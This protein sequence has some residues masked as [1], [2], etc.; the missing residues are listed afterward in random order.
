MALCV[1]SA[2]IDPIDDIEL[3]D[4]LMLVYRDGGFT[5]SE[6]A[7]TIFEPAAVRARGEIL[8]EDGANEGLLGMVIVVPPTSSAAQFAQAGECEMQLLA[9]A[10]RVQRAG[11]GRAL[12]KAAME[13]A[14]SDGFIRMLLWTQ[15]AM[16][17]AQRLYESSG[18]TRIPERDFKRLGRDF[19][20]FEAT[21]I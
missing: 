13:R 15:L 18:F 14:Q 2:R 10:P 9:T 11:I 21:L 19:L 1:R 12:L 20:F 16:H 4:L 8:Y 17:A 7:E 6:R 3:R 5:D